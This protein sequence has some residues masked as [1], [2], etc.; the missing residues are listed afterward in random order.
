MLRVDRRDNINVDINKI[1]TG[2]ERVGR[3]LRSRDEFKCYVAHVCHLRFLYTA[4][5]DRVVSLVHR[6]RAGGCRV[7][8]A[9]GATD[10]SL[11][12]TDQTP[13]GTH[14]ASCAMCTGVLS[15]GGNAARA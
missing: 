2:F 10:V 4:G 14:P 12:L 6:L 1:L 7:R 8:I 11:L 9:A 15:P 5:S 13:S 3:G